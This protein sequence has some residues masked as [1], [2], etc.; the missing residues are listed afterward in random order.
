MRATLA[1]PTLALASIAL[2]LAA[3]SFLSPP[4]VE[5]S[6]LASYE[7]A[8]VA[9]RGRWASADR[10]VGDEHVARI[11]LPPSASRPPVGASVDVVGIVTRLPSGALVL[12]ARSLAHAGEA[13]LT[14]CDVTAS[15]GAF[16]GEPLLVRGRVEEGATRTI[17]D[18]ACA[19]AVSG[20]IDPSARI[21]RGVLSFAP[22]DGRATLRVLE[23]TS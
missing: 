3:D 22:H 18:G 23:W 10:L 1:A 8:E 13:V 12:E 19:L 14:V 17:R 7:G 9:L 5:I 4:F 6:E 16:A 20:K 21:A 2:L 11:R 15:P